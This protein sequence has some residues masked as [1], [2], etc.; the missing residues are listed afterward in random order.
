MSKPKERRAEVKGGEEEMKVT[1]N[2]IKNSKQWE[3]GWKLE[4]SAEHENKITEFDSLRIIEQTIAIAVPDKL[5]E[6]IVGHQNMINA[7]KRIISNNGSHGIDGMSVKEFM[8]YFIEHEEEIRKSV[9]EGKY[10]PQPTRRVEIPKEDGTMRKLGIPT[11]LDRVI[12][13][14]IAQV[15]SPIYEPQFSENSFG[16]RPNRSQHKAIR[17]AQKYIQEGYIEGIS[18][19]LEKYFDTVNHSKLIQ[20]LSETIKDGRVISLIHKYLN[21]GV[22]NEEV[23]EATEEGFAQGGNISPLL[24]NIMLDVLD[25][26]LERRGLRF[27]RFADDTIIFVKSR[28]SAERVSEGITEFIEKKLKLKVNQD[29]TKVGKATQMKYLGFSF[30]IASGRNVRIR[31]HPI[32]IKKM[33]NRIREITKRNNGHGYR[34]L[35]EELRKYIVGWV[36]Y[37]KIADMRAILQRIDSWLRHK[38]RCYIWKSWKTY[39]GRNKR[40]KQLGASEEQAKMLAGSRKGLWATSGFQDLN[41][42]ITKERL[43]RAGYPTFIK[44]YL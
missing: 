43:E 32:S 24:S 36:N 27:V 21:A 8:P 41:F 42:I 20:I 10:K 34:R 9:L 1:E 6:E 7:C 13:Q 30:Y 28:K 37:F 22:M 26:E 39:K 23:Y 31:I 33:E 4:G 5:M 19:D 17:K 18:I 40:L 3:A 38:I 25:K 29:K 16:F 35:K 2:E 14:S 15:L 12:Q 44:Y 11:V